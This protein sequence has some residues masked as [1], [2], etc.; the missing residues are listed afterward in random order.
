MSRISPYH[1]LSVILILVLCHK[2][3]QATEFPAIKVV[4]E[5][6]YPIN[7]TDETSQAMTGF[8]TD[9]LL[10]VLKQSDINYSINSYTWERSYKI[11]SEEPNVLIYSMARTPERENNFHWLF[12]IMTL[13]YSLYGIESRRVH[14]KDATD[15]RD[16]QIALTAGSASL[17]Y[18]REDGY[19]NIVVAKDYEHLDN[20]IKHGRIDFVASSKLALTSFMNKY[21]YEKDTFR[22]Y[23]ELNYVDIDLYYAMSKGTDKRLVDTLSALLKENK[24][25]LRLP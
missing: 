1:F 9:Y 7:H 23:K 2:S 19:N 18:L 24:T 3:L 10:G 21:N 20:L 4:T 15:F 25:E 16:F 22:P 12:E 14:F 11:A 5:E 13:K 17:K 6:S 8:A